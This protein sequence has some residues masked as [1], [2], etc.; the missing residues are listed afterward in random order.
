MPVIHFFKKKSKIISILGAILFC[1]I[2]FFSFCLFYKDSPFLEK[3]SFIEKRIFN[4]I[5][6]YT[7][8]F[9]IN[10]T[11]KEIKSTN[12]PIIEYEYKKRISKTEIYKLKKAFSS[13]K[14][15]LFIINDYSL[16]DAD[17]YS[18]YHDNFFS[19]LV[20]LDIDHLNSGFIRQ[21]S[22]L[23]NIDDSY[24]QKHYFLD[25]KGDVSLLP[26]Y[27]HQNQFIFSLTDLY[28]QSFY[29]PQFQKS[30][31]NLKYPVFLKIH[32]VNHLKISQLKK[33][34]YIDALSL[35]I[36]EIKYTNENNLF[37]IHFD[38]KILYSQKNEQLNTRS[39][40]NSNQ[41]DTIK[42]K[43][44]KLNTDFYIELN[45][46]RSRIE[47]HYQQK[48][49]KLTKY[50]RNSDL[51]IHY[52]MDILSVFLKEENFFYTGD[53]LVELSELFEKISQENSKY[54][55]DYLFFKR[56]ANQCYRIN[57]DRVIFNVSD[58]SR[59]LSLRD[60]I[61]L[62]GIRLQN[63]LLVEKESFLMNLPLQMLCHYYELFPQQLDI[64][65]GKNII[66]SILPEIKDQE[67]QNI[68]IPIDRKGNIQLLGNHH[69]QNQ[70]DI[71]DLTRVLNAA[72]PANKK[73]IIIKN[74]INTEN[75]YLTNTVQQSISAFRSLIQQKYFY[76]LTFYQYIV[77]FH[78]VLILHLLILMITDKKCK[79][80]N[81]V[82]LNM[83][84]LI[85]S[86]FMYLKYFILVHFLCFIFLS[87]LCCFS[88]FFIFQFSSV[89]LE[90]QPV[91]R[92][93]KL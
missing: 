5:D 7:N 31:Q 75:S 40:L 30:N 83:I 73:I 84:I 88:N 60:L 54:K 8:F 90:N 28:N 67:K 59:L 78:I 46:L 85:F 24:Y 12:I 2:I 47:T 79:I 56:L 16:H 55:K 13:S 72:S 69:R 37:S 82:F 62:P 36:P 45:K 58:Q 15:K 76:E 52:Q 53:F 68:L 48:I 41:I 71:D 34:L 38:S 33:G 92:N 42:A 77:F 49:E 89:I 1:D 86:L 6:Y 27:H 26:S 91:K 61:V 50:L 20:I 43:I 74:F 70:Q 64:M 57:P 11:K 19:N 18:I 22:S 25:I 39:T 17:Y 14:V 93:C 80:I 81:V 44:D 65:I 3:I 87:M 10:T 35:K 9:K 66:Y 51:D 29:H 21:N 32:T 23:S 63:Q 4:E